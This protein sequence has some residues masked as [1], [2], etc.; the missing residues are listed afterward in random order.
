M[1]TVFNPS[2]DDKN[3]AAFIRDANMNKKTLA[4]IKA[5]IKARKLVFDTA[6]KGRRT[7]YAIGVRAGF[8]TC[9]DVIRHLELAE[10]NDGA[11]S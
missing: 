10:K 3:G 7:P 11:K 2:D 9:L 4:Q 8:A 1:G 6:F 5:A